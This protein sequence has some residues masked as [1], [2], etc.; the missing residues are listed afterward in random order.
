MLNDLIGSLYAWVIGPA[1][2][3]ILGC[4]RPEDLHAY[5]V[6][7]LGGWEGP[8]SAGLDVEDLVEP[9]DRQD[10]AGRR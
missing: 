3:S 10:A 8:V 5:I 9:G 7:Q 2:R 4:I 1:H 6:E